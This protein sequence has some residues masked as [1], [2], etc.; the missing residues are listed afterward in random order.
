MPY[1]SPEV[2]T[3][4]LRGSTPSY[5][6]VCKAGTC[7]AGEWHWNVDPMRAEAAAIEEFDDHVAEAHDCD[8]HESLAGEHMGE[9]VYCDGGCR[10]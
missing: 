10:A 3:T 2:E 5:R 8:G 9:A 6:A 4:S 1:P 7:W